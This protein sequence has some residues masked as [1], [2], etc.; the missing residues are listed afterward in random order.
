MRSVVR[1]NPLADGLKVTVKVVLPPEGGIVLSIPAVFTMNSAAFSPDR[2]TLLIVS[3]LLPVFRMVKVFG[4]LAVPAS[5]Q[6]E[7]AAERGEQALVGNV[8][9][10]LL[11]ERGV[12]LR[13][14][15]VFDGIADDGVAVHGG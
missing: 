1:G 8:L 9:R 11:R 4:A 12:D 6:L 14:L 10:G 15:A 2:P 3:G 13:R 5:A 7:D